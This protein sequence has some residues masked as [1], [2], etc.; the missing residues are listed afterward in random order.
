[1]ADGAEVG[2]RCIG[3]YDFD[4]IRSDNLTFKAGDV[5]TIIEMDESGWWKGVNPDGE[6]GIFPYNYVEAEKPA[7][8]EQNVLVALADLEAQFEGSLTFYEGDLLV[9]IKPINED[10]SEGKL[11]D[12][13]VVGVY[14][15]NFFEPVENG[16]EN[17]RAISSRA[18]ETERLEREE[19]ERL[20]EAER[21]RREKE[22]LELRLKEEEEARERQKEALLE[23]QRLAREEEAAR[24]KQEDDA[25]RKTAIMEAKAEADRFREEIRLLKQKLAEEEKTREEAKQEMEKQA[26]LARQRAAEAEAEAQRAKAEAAALRRQQEMIDARTSQAVQRKLENEQQVFQDKWRASMAF[27]S[28]LG[29]RDLPALPS[30]TENAVISPVYVVET[31]T[32]ASPNIVRSESK[33]HSSLFTKEPEYANTSL[34]PTEKNSRKNQI[35]PVYVSDEADAQEHMD[36]AKKNFSMLTSGPQDKVPSSLKRN[37]ANSVA[38]TPKVESFGERNRGKKKAKPKIPSKFARL[39][40]GDPC[41]SCGKTVAFG[42]E[43]LKALDK[44]WHKECFKCVECDKVLRYGTHLEHS[45]MPYCDGCHKKVTGISKYVR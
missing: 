3:I 40:G 7:A 21:L 28:G 6:V 38:T 24:K 8:Q 2:M 15:N 18:E 5:I 1:M 41:A 14:P 36:V 33:P 17:E 45:N 42:P 9:P 11:L 43:K 10:W 19:R 26:E 16:V 31:D 37:K 44:L 12:S 35:T 4:G 34:K 23:Q 32:P 22:E 13:G 25:K 20:E 29:A 27:N 39:G 30:K